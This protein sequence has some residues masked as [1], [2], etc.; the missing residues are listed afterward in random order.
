MRTWILTIFA[1]AIPASGCTRNAATFWEEYSRLECRFSKKCHKARFNDLYDD[2]AECRDEAADV[3]SP[4]DFEDACEDYDND[5]ARECLAEMRKQVRKCE[6]ESNDNDC[7]LTKI[8]GDDLEIMQDVNACVQGIGNDGPD[9][10]PPDTTG[11]EVPLFDELS[12]LPDDGEDPA[13]PDEDE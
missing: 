8:C 7:S 9:G 2:M 6:S 4:D 12:Q 10:L 3:C 13:T 5:E 11:L 1:L